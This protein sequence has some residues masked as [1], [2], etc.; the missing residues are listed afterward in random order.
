MNLLFFQLLEGQG[1][2]QC[3]DIGIKMNLIRFIHLHSHKI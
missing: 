3:I 2:N 1:Y